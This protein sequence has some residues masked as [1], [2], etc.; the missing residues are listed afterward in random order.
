MLRGRIPEAVFASYLIRI[1]LSDYS[2][3]EYV[4]YFFHSNS[5]WVQIYKGQIGIGQPNVNSKTLSKIVLP[6]P[7]LPEQHAIAKRVKTL[8]QFA[9]KVEQRVAAATTHANQLT[10][11]LRAKAFRGELVPQDPND[12]PATVLLERIKKEKAEQEE[13]KKAQKRKSRTLLDY[14]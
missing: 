8:F 12:E 11:T 9:D 10:K 1:I 6:L 4:A 13:M 5:Y 2:Q 14:N 3:K 7:P